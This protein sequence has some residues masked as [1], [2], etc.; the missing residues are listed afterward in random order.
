MNN[1]EN[2]DKCLKYAQAYIIPQKFENLYSLMNNIRMLQFAAIELNLYLD[3]FP[4]NKEATKKYKE[5]SPKL[6]ELINDYEVKYGPIRNFGDA[7]V[8][9]PIAWTESPWP[10]E[11]QR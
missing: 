10:W 8:E 11:K 5:I 9:D 4:E 7:Y 3:N 6:D 2:R 1:C